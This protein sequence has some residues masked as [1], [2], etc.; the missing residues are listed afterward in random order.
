MFDPTLQRWL[1]RSFRSSSSAATPPGAVVAG[2]GG[3][4]WRRSA[5]S[6]PAARSRAPARPSRRSRSRLGFD[7]ARDRI[8]PGANDNLSA[9]AALV[10]IAERLNGSP[11]R[12]PRT[13]GPC[14]AEEVLQGGI[15]GF[16][17]RHSRRGTRPDLVPQLDTI[18]SPELIM[19]EGE[20]CFVIE[21]YR[22]RSFAT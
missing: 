3:P 11:W 7:I 19:L 17:D 21:D 18:G 4:A 8:V 6:P 9:V 2:V 16:A 22:A 1:A 5:R 12:D 15:Y 10:A 13:A 14:G 20:G